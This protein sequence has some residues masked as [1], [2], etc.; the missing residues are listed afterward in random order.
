MTKIVNLRQR[1]SRDNREHRPAECAHRH[2][3]LDSHGGIVTC[4]TCKAMLTP[5]WALSMLS[6]QYEL[7]LE[8]IVRL[9]KRLTLADERIA[10][11]SAEPAAAQSRSKDAVK[12]DDRGLD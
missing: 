2:I 10:A 4:V 9:T 11:L 1:I 3:N 8:N 7:A 6:G 5:F 12:S